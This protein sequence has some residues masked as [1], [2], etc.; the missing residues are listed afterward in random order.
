MYQ[1]NKLEISLNT[2]VFKSKLGL[3]FHLIINK[4]IKLSFRSKT[5]SGKWKLSETNDK[6]FIFLS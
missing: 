6:I 1:G 4:T 3:Q 2:V 5:I